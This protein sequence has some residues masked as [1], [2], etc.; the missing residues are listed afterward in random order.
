MTVEIVNP[1][2]SLPLHY[3]DGSLMDSVGNIFP[4]INGVPR[5]ANLDN[6]T[7]SFGVQWNK[8]Y[9]TQLD[10]EEDGLVLSQNRFFAVSAWSQ[11]DLL[12]KDVLEVGSGA[13]RFS[14]VVLE[15]TEAQLYSVDYSD[16]VSANINNNGKTAPD[17]FHLFQASIYEMPFLN[18]SFDK[19]FCFGVLQ[20]TP[21]FRLSIK[22]L[23]EKS[24]PGGE[25]VVDFYP[26][27]G[28]WTKVHAKY[29]FRPWTKKLSHE[30]LFRIIECNVDWL[31][32]VSRFLNKVG[33]VVLTRLI[34]IVDITTLPNVGLNKEQLRE[35]V[36][37]DTFDMFSPEHDNPQRI[38]DVVEMFCNFGATVTFSGF[39]EYADGFTAAV[40]RG[41]KK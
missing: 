36:V 39:V 15:H 3:K 38:K 41:I 16:A 34:P 14:K 2:N 23:I 9:K 13:G 8:F 35:W 25:V 12:G 37:L 20:H 17:R 31:I 22:A 19:I 11:V 4:I 30:D 32:K 1:Q 21:D 5:I 28:W 24:K 6:Y 7:E 29:I 26:I 33:L 27:K 10:R 40:V 18:N